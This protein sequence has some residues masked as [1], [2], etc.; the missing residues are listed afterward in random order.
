MEQSNLQLKQTCT[1]IVA[2]MESL[3]AGVMTLKEETVASK[4]NK[5]NE[6]V[7]LGRN[8]LLTEKKQEYE[9]KSVA[10]KEVKKQLDYL[11]KT[12][13]QDSNYEWMNE[14]ENKI[15]TD[16]QTLLRLQQENAELQKI[17]DK[18]DKLLSQNEDLMQKSQDVQNMRD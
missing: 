3:V 17:H 5:V 7:Y 16:K 11:K 12:F 15:K 4:K 9:Q 13:T 2:T 10:Y 8:E 18:H 14:T 6:R 1:D